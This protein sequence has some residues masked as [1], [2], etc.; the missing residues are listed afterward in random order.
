MQVLVSSNHSVTAGEDLIA[1]VE[2][3]VT[4][5]L[6]R[7]GD[8]ITRVEVHLAD[9][10]S[11]HKIGKTDKYCS[12]EAHVAGL[13]PVTVKDHAGSLD[14][15]IEGAIDKLWRALDHQLGRLQERPDDGPPEK[16][17]ATTQEL[18]DLERAESQQPTASRKRKQRS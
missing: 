6:S 3:S 1:M 12:M 17:V 10:N 11:G 2:S 14:V 16:D 15:A 4:D 18:V 13:G 5:G 7:F 8:R 9:D